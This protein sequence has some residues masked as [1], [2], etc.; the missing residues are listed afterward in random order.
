ML[1]TAGRLWLAGAPIDWPGLHGGERRRRV[2]LPTYPFE[3]QRYWVALS[4]PGRAA[5]RMAA[6]EPVQPADPGEPTPEAA[7][8]DLGDDPILNRIAA[9]WREALGVRSVRRDDR[10]FDLGGDS[11]VA[12][13]VMARLRELFP[14][15]LP[16]RRLFETPTLAGLSA[17][18]EEALV[19][20]LEELPEEEAERLAASYLA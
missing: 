5:G 10:F 7:P 2:P 13:Q 18:V 4:G 17:A 3:R 14:V 15:D 9:I 1:A 20:K 6:A 11:L 8:A 19:Q 16:V 12:L